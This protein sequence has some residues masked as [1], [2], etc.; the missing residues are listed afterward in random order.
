MAIG[1]IIGRT[2]AADAQS[3]VTGGVAPLVLVALHRLVSVLR[4]LEPVSLTLLRKDDPP[5]ADTDV[6]ANALAHALGTPSPVDHEAP[7]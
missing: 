1:A 5:V 2:A 3:F 4:F 6:M 7:H